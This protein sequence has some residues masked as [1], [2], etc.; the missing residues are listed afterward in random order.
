MTSHQT[1]MSFKEQR[2]K[3][4]YA[5][6]R[7]RDAEKVVKEIEANTVSY[8]LAIEEAAASI[9]RAL[10]WLDEAIYSREEQK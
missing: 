8:D 1:T 9:D 3:L 10:G 7:C 2:V 6:K 5:R 4:L